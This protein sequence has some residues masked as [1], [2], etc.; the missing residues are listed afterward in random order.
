MTTRTPSRVAATIDINHLRIGDFYQA[1]TQ[2]GEISVGEYLGIEVT[3][4]DWRIIL[5]GRSCTGSIAV[6]ALASV[7]GAAA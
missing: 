1:T 5:R 2:A 6:D 4:G 7:Y 3:Y